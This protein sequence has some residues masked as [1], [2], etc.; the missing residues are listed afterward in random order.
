MM[1]QDACSNPTQK[2]TKWS[3]WGDDETTTLYA[4]YARL[5][6]RLA[7]YFAELAR[8]AHATGKPIAMHPFLLFPK[9]AE[10]WKVDDAFFLG[11]ALY[12]MPVVRRGETQKKGW[13]PPGDYVDLEDDTA[14][15]G[16]KVVTI[17]APLGKLP[18]LLVAGEILPLLDPTIDTL[19]DATDPDVVTPSDVADRLDLVV[20]LAP[21][22]GAKLTLADGTIVEA[23]RGDSD[24]GN[25]ASLTSVEPAAVA[26]CAACYSK[27]AHGDVSRL[28]VTTA[29]AAS[30]DVT[31][32]DLHLVASGPSARR[33]RWDVRRLP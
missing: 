23:S 1:E 29:L 6:T 31:L 32:E 26:D 9:E 15:E 16:G 11:P 28:R 13:L 4:K 19:A 2:K 18:L 7:P 33:L 20:A 27:E 3:L 21:G 10:A 12:A 25:P 24:A 30:S 5:H 8:E 17:D 14:Y 22:S